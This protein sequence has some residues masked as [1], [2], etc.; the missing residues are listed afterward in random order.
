MGK[1]VGVTGLET[2]G[3]GGSDR[4]TYAEGLGIS[5]IQLAE[6]LDGKGSDDLLASSPICNIAESNPS[7]S[8][9]D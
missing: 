5:P 4:A 9:K 3:R 6:E 7:A 2:C 8:G 1:S